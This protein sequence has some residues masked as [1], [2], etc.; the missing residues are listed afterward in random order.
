MTE[1]SQVEDQNTKIHDKMERARMTMAREQAESQKIKEQLAALEQEIETGKAELMKLVAREA[2]YRNVCQNASNNKESLQRRLKTIEREELE[3]SQ[4]VKGLQ[5]KEAQAK[6]KL[7]SYQTQIDELEKQ[8]VA[9]Q[10]KIREKSN[11]LGGQIKQVQT[12]ELKRNEAKSTYTTLKKM[13]DNFEWYK[14]GVK[15]IMK[16][17]T[18][19]WDSNSEQAPGSGDSN[20]VIGLMANI[21][22]PEPNF[23]TAVEAALGESLQYILVKDQNAGIESIRYLRTTGTG[24]SG[25]IPVSHLDNIEPVQDKALDL[26]KRLMDHVR[27][28]KGFEKIAEAFLGHVVLADDIQE[29]ISIFNGNGAYQSIVTKDGD[30]ISNS[31]IIIGGSRDKLS[32]IL[33]EKRK[34]KTIG[35]KID[36]LNQQLDSA[37]HDQK[38]MESEVRDIEHQL[39]KMLE[40]K[41]KATD[42]EVEAEKALYK[43]TEDL[44][45]TRRHLEIVRLEKEQLQGEDSDLDMEIAKYHKALEE[46]E[47]RVKAAQQLLSKK[48]EQINAV[49]STMEDYNQ[50][51]VDIKLELTGLNASL[52]SSNNT[53]K[54]LKEFQN[55]GLD[56]IEQVSQDI[57]RKEE[58]RSTSKHR[59]Q[60]YEQVLSHIYDDLKHVERKLENNEADYGTI[61]AKL[62]DSD[63]VISN[64][65]N[66]RDET[67]QKIRL[68]E[69]EKSE[70]QIKRENI[71]VR[72]K[73]NYNQ[74]ILALGSEYDRDTE[75]SV[76]PIDEMED[77]LARLK[78]KIIKME[79]VNLGAIKEYEQLK[80]RFDFLN[81]H[82][83]DLVKAVEDLHKVI[84]K[85][86]RVT[87]KRFLE[88]FDAINEKLNEVF[89][90]LFDG[91]SAKLILTDPG[92]PLET[93]VEF[94]I[95]P[96]GKKLTR[97]SLLSGG[98]K[99]LSAIALIFS[100]FL[101]KPA[102]FCFMDEIDAP[103]D[104]ANL[105]RFS[106]LLQIVREKSQIVMVTHNKKTME[107]AD[108]LFGITME[109]KGVSKVVSVNFQHAEG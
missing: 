90:R 5:K 73:E 105:F 57:F 97:M 27:V 45:H 106:D 8:V 80:E 103:L 84:K 21:I 47:N 54:R 101:I 61:D 59:I 74:S 32:G 29:A 22:E 23:E 16:D 89:P 91:G 93:G 70:Q 77:N 104:D 109:K 56:R 46:I 2:Q 50:G 11:L 41:R 83:D 14:D 17:R 82:R 55:D 87:Q 78:S 102:S 35:R 76:M 10:A 107:F 3:T 81:E 52:E 28:E 68:L 75:Q 71:A 63:T 36:G 34:I 31:G 58:K 40:S 94:M 51:I 4:K 85:I 43:V 98:E 86:N 92:N 19:S 72:L 79:D 65:Q 96:Q 67:L 39:Q 95:H 30:V 12:L 88:T 49:S 100:A 99:A 25:F 13:E 44:K 42:S 60:E 37:R 6:D 64:I 20:G 26:S 9:I 7:V 48:I 38:K 33:T 69:L 53:L 15:A 18:A 62:K 66:K 1:I 108:M 24:R